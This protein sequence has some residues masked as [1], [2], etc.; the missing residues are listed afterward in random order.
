MANCARV[1]H[2]SMPTYPGYLADAW[3]YF[4][5]QKGDCVCVYD[6]DELI[7]IGRFTVLPDGTGWLCECGAGNN[8]NFCTNCGAARP[9]KEVVC[10][11]CGYKPEGEAPKFC[12]ECGAKF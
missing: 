7:G 8:G 5:T 4:S 1:E 11:G 10:T 3:H 2:E 12:P 6:G 9:V